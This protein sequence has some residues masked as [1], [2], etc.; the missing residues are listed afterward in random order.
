MEIELFKGQAPEELS[1]IE[2]TYAL[3]E[4]TGEIHDFN[5]ILEVIQ[6]FFSLSDKELE[7]IMPRL[8][9]DIN[10]DGRFISLGD[11]RWGLRSWYAIDAIDEEIV[12]S[13]DDEDLP[14]HQRRKKKRRINVHDEND[15]GMIDYNDDDPEDIDDIYDQVDEDDYDDEDEDE[16]DDGLTEIDLEEDEDEN[17]ELDDYSSDLD[18]FDDA[19]IDEDLDIDEADDEEDFEDEED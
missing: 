13:L 7:E 8:Y 16:D 5:Q 11:N 18:E 10:I 12:N 4:E 1:M 3:L 14:R 9:T 19:D 17:T 2:V 6:D 15:E